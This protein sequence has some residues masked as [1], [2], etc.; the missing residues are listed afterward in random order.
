MGQHEGK[1][2]ERKRQSGQRAEN[3]K[4]SHLLAFYFLL[5]EEKFY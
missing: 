4:S 5:V 1:V 3:D 2:D